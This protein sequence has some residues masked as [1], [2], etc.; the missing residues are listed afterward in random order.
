M[1]MILMLYDRV[2]QILNAAKQAL[3]FVQNRYR[4]RVIHKVF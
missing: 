3:D 4:G 2:P 1:V